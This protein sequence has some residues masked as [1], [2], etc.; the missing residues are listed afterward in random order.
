MESCYLC[1]NMDRLRVYY[2]SEIS[3]RKANTV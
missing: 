2:V 1:D 3:Q